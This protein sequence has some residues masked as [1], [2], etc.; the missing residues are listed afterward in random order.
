MALVILLVWDHPKAFLSVLIEI[1]TWLDVDLL[2]Y[3][4]EDKR[5]NAKTNKCELAKPRR[6][7]L[8]LDHQIR[9]H[10]YGSAAVVGHRVA[11][12]IPKLTW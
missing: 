12:D 4:F 6:L 7:H 2:Q 8:Q 10:S 11:V 9:E 5:Q 3:D 1:L